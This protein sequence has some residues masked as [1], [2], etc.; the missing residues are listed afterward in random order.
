M[1]IRLFLRPLFALLFLCLLPAGAA[2]AYEADFSLPE[3]A[4][5]LRIVYT[6]GAKGELYPCPT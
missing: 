3:P 2:R 4:P 5:L 1:Q 6:A